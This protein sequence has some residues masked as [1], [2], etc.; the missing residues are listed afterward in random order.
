MYCSNEARKHTVGKL[1]SDLVIN[2]DEYAPKI[3]LKAILDSVLYQAKELKQ[4]LI[5]K[6]SSLFFD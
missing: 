2:K 1:I 4:Y 3:L 6:K 5:Q